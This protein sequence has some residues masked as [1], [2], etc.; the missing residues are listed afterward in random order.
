MLVGVG[1]GWGQVPCAE[2]NAFQQQH[3][4]VPWVLAAA[5]SEHTIPCGLP[6]LRGA[7]RLF[8]CLLTAHDGVGVGGPCV[9]GGLV[10]AFEVDDE[11]VRATR[12]G[13]GGGVGHLQFVRVVVALS[14]SVRAERA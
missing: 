13:G 3:L 4:V 11:D 10:C 7:W 12:G 9:C 1:A 2:A 14:E 6:R 8:R 5:A